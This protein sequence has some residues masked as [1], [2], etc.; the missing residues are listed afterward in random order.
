[1]ALE[2]ILFLGEII[3]G[4]FFENTRDA[5]LYLGGAAGLSAGVYA[6]W[7]TGVEAYDKHV[8]QKLLKGYSS[9][10]YDDELKKI[11]PEHSSNPKQLIKSSEPKLNIN[12]FQNKKLPNKK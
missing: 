9:K 3:E 12:K 8:I 2:G 1:M 6:L 4:G 7:K 10:D 5:V 11:N